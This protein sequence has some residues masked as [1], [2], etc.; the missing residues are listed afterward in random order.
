MSGER[1]DYHPGHPA[2]QAAFTMAGLGVL[3]FHLTSLIDLI[4]PA[5]ASQVHSRVDSA[6]RRALQR[7]WSLVW[8]QL[9]TK[10]TRYTSGAGRP[11]MIG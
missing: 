7:R 11:S 9:F 10:A 5:N 1:S 2:D 4:D 3:F 8:S 6:R